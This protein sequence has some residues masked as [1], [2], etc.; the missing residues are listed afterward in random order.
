MGSTF[1]LPV[2]RADLPAIVERLRN[3]GLTL[4][5]T[6]VRGGDDYCGIPLTGPCALFFGGEGSGLDRAFLDSLDLAISIPLE[7]GVESLSVGAAVAVT[8]FEARRQRRLN[9]S[10]IPGE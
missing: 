4:V 2:E 10:V 5:G 6:C 7:K 9:P 1:R 3:E 8:L